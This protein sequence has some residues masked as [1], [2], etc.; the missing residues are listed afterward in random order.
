MGPRTRPWRPNTVTKP[1]KWRKHVGTAPAW[2]ESPPATYGIGMLRVLL[3]VVGAIV[4]VFVAAAV[5][6]TLFWLA[7]IALIVGVLGMSLGVFRA[8]RRSARSPRR[9]Y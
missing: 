5:I 8:R 6:K 2:R 7:L 1:L 9:R 4:I 3:I